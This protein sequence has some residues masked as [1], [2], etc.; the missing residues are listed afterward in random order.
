MK[1]QETIPSFHL[2]LRPKTNA[3]IL[4]D[5]VHMLRGEH[6]REE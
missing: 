3:A 6:M 1:Y 2:D 4:L 5:I